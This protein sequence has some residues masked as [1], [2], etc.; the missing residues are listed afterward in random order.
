V[1]L[2]R[3]ASATVLTALGAFFNF[4]LADERRFRGWQSGLLWADWRPKP[5]FHVVRNAV[6]AVERHAVTC[7]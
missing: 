6:G 5:S 3:T 4:Q 7:A 1:P 2:G